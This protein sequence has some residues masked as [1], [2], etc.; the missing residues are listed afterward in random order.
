[1]VPSIV[2][3]GTQIQIFKTYHYLYLSFNSALMCFL[4]PLDYSKVVLHAKIIMVNSGL[5]YR[6][7]EI[8]LF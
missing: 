5:R 8:Q 1:M 3:L 7:H 4:R 2:M 6:F